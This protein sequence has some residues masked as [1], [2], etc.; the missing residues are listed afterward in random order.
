MTLLLLDS[1]YRETIGP[2]VY[3]GSIDVISGDYPNFNRQLYEMAEALSRSPH[4]KIIDSYASNWWENKPWDGQ[5]YDPGPPPLYRPSASYVGKRY[6]GDP[7]ADVSVRNSGQ[8]YPIWDH[9]A[10]VGYDNPWFVAECQTENPAL[11]AMGFSGLQKWQIKFQHHSRN[12]PGNFID[13]SDP[14]GVKYPRFHDDDD[15]MVARISP[16]GGW[17]LADTDPDF[18]PSSPPL[19]VGTPPT[20]DNMRIHIG[21]GDADQRTQFILTADGMLAILATTSFGG[22]EMTKFG[23]WAGDVIPKTTSHMPMPR[24]LFTDEGGYDGFDQ[25]GFLKEAGSWSSTR[26]W[27]FWDNNNDLRF[28]KSYKTHRKSTMRDALPSAGDGYTKV[29]A[30]P[31]IVFLNNPDGFVFQIGHLLETYSNGIHLSYDKN[32]LYT[33]NL[34]WCT[35]FPWDGVTEPYDGY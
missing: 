34:G 14:S 16:W 15:I 23:L 1:L 33:N 19:P 30:Y 12:G 6:K 17:D 29:G 27:S 31:I 32:W 10:E 13:V 28:Y 18:N 25:V 11:A 22:K 35:V 20:H 26:R 3:R 7:I 4:F 21:G 2:R 9:Y 8:S 24:A 5:E